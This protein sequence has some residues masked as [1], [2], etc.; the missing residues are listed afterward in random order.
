MG[1]VKEMGSLVGA[2]IW[3]KN[4]TNFDHHETTK[5]ALCYGYVQ[6]NENRSYSVVF[7]CAKHLYDGAKVLHL[8]DEPRYYWDMRTLLAHLVPDGELDKNGQDVIA[9]LAKSFEEAKS[10]PR[11]LRRTTSLSSSSS[12]SSAPLSS[13]TNAP[14][15]QQRHPE[16]P[17]QQQQQQQQ[18]RPRP[19]QSI[20]APANTHSGGGGGGG[21]TKATK[22]K[23]R[24]QR[25]RGRRALTFV[26]PDKSRT[27]RGE[28]LLEGARKDQSGSGGGGHLG[29]SLEH[30]VRL[31]QRQ[32]VPSNGQRAH[33]LHDQRIEDRTSRGGCRLLWLV[34]RRREPCEFWRGRS[35]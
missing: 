19:Q 13:Y 1:D 21:K 9:A 29:P 35:R 33:H 10:S 31:L 14:A 3:S 11:K 27:Q 20:D 25:S 22:K 18:R 26:D 2:R 15:K 5:G 32:G 16:P 23:S 17:Q 12:S 4:M 7:M 34:R 8:E 6:N 30:G 24:T 28:V